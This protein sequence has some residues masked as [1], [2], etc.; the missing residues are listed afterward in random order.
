MNP[1]RKCEVAIVDDGASVAATYAA[2]RW[3][4][5]DCPWP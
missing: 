4:L 5:L 2:Y 3:S 1:P